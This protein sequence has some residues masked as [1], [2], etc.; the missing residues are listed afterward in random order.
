MKST[1]IENVSTFIVFLISTIIVSTYA[2]FFTRNFAV[3]QPSYIAT[4]FVTYAIAKAFTNIFWIPLAICVSLLMN[5]VK[6]NKKSFADSLII[7]TTFIAMD[8]FLYTVLFASAL[9]WHII[10]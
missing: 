9:A 4:F 6:K 1:T 8:L 2:A 5:H 10:L 3:D 7:P